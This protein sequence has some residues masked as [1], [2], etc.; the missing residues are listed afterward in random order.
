[1]EKCYKCGVSS[2]RAKLYDV[3][4]KK[5]IVKICERCNSFEKLPLV[6]KVDSNKVLEEV[7][8]R[9]QTY[10]E[11][12]DK[13]FSK[14]E[15]TLRDL[16]D[17]RRNVEKQENPEDLVDNFYWVIK[18]VRRLRKITLTQLSKEIN[19]PEETLKML[20]EGIIPSG[21]YRIVNKIEDY[22]HINLRKKGHEREDLQNRKRAILDNS[23]IK[24]EE[25]K[26]VVINEDEEK[27]IEDEKQEEKESFFS[28]IFKKFKKE[29]GNET[30]INNE[31]AEDLLN[32]KN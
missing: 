3:I 12:F 21:V 1:M 19:E 4:S 17:K 15:P 24:G 13:K 14:K 8:K 22:F 7:N 6:K 18:R 9:P 27:E 30:N 32:D 16:I 28:K 29:K 31:E 23:L 25:D 20:E 2:E 10:Q 5:G 11:K 26:I